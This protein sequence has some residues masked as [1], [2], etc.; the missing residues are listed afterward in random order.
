M[1]LQQRQTIEN[2]RPDFVEDRLFDVLSNGRRRRILR[3]LHRD[4]PLELPTLAERVAAIEME[5]TVDDLDAQARKRVYISC[6]QTHVPRLVKADL[7]EHD[8]DT[9][10][11]SPTPELATLTTLLDLPTPSNSPYPLLALGLL[12]TAFY[13][14]VL[15]NL[16]LFG[17]IPLSLAGAIVVLILFGYGLYSAISYW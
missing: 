11:V 1:T 14:S 6:Y 13:L 5:T 9:G 17:A 3:V 4:G 16:P 15:L 7:V 8:T 2:P 10:I 12:S